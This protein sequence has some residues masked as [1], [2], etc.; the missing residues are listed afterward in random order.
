MNGTA[1]YHV[2]KIYEHVKSASARGEVFPFWATCVGIHDMV[3]LASGRVYK[4]FLTRTYAEN[5]ALPLRFEA[6]EDLL[7]DEVLLPGLALTFLKAFGWFR[8]F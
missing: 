5:L 2:R 3:Q 6:P 7:F 8:H 1:D 4:E